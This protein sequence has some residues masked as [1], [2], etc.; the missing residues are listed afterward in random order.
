[1]DSSNSGGGGGGGSKIS[2]H[3]MR[4]AL[5]NGDWRMAR[6]LAEEA[7]DLMARQ[8]DLQQAVDEVEQAL[9]QRAA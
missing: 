9:R 1:M 2:A 6:I 7:R 5:A 8:G 3:T 4:E